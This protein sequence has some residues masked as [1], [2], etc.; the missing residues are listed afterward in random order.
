MTTDHL[1]MVDDSVGS[2]RS[3]T[4]LEFVDPV[5]PWSIRTGSSFVASL[6]SASPDWLQGVAE[7]VYSS[8]SANSFVDNG[9]VNRAMKFLSELPR[10]VGRPHAAVGEG[11]EIGFEWESRRSGELYLTF[12]PYGD[13]AYW[14]D[15]RCSEEWEA[16]LEQAAQ[17]TLALV[18]VPL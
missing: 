10:W 8:A 1:E 11:G 18:R 15:D 5:G 9:A 12:S 16:P 4:V 6:S 3:T 13:S 7:Q 2:A 17:L 14:F